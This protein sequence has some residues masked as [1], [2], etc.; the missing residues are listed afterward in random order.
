MADQL[1]KRNWPQL[2]ANSQ[3]QMVM[4]PDKFVKDFEEVEKKRKAFNEFLN[5]IAEKEIR[6]NFETQKVFFALREYLA[7][8]GHGQIWSKDVGLNIDAL[9]DGSF[10]VNISEQ[11]RRS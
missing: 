1:E 7:K 10:V 8:N 3:S 11:N 4:L 9:K 2:C 6:L 5:E